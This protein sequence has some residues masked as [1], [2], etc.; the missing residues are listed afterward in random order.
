MNS[1]TRAGNCGCTPLGLHRRTRTSSPNE[2]ELSKPRN[3]KG[4]NPLASN[5]SRKRRPCFGLCRQDANTLHKTELT[6]LTL[7]RSFVG[8]S[9]FPPRRV[10]PSSND[11]SDTLSERRDSYMHIHSRN[12]LISWMCM[13]TPT[14]PGVS[15][16]A[17]AP[18]EELLCTA[19]TT[20]STGRRPRLQFA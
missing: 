14:S 8:N 11:W 9:P 15:R 12:R 3:W 18:V 2:Q 10:T 16:H 17:V 1:I 19:N 7:L 4:L 13:S 5:S 6:S 20:L